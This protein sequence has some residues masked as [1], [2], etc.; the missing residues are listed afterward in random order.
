M[1]RRALKAIGLFD[2]PAPE[3]PPEPSP[4]DAL[5]EMAARGAAAQQAV[6][7]L[8]AGP[9]KRVKRTKAEPRRSGRLETA[10]FRVYGDQRQ[11]LAEEAA[12]R[13]P[14][15]VY[16]KLDSS[17]VLREVIDFWIAH[18]HEHAEDR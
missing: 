15:W 18:R 12:A 14:E 4:V 11:V 6:N 10:T 8:G 13:Q 7:E 16:G 1:A 17:E 3:A 2:P 5:A 9:P